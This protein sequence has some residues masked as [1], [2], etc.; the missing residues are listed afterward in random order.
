M[1]LIRPFEESDSPEM[2]EIEKLC[3]HGDEKYA[4]GVRKFDIISRYKMYDNWKV[5]VA[6]EDGRVV[7]WIGWTMKGETSSGTYTYLVE[8]MVHPEFR[9]K[10]IALELSKVVEERAREI[11]ANHIYCYIFEPNFASRSLFEMQGYTD[12]LD[13]K[14]CAKSVYKESKLSNKFQIERFAEEDL[15]EIIQLL[16]TYN[17]GYIHY[18]AFTPDSFLSHLNSIP[19]YGSDNYWVA[20]EGDR[21]AACAGLWDSSLIA[22]TCYTR[23]PFMWKLMG[24]ILRPLGKFMKVQKIPAEG[25][26]F[27]V[28]YITDYAFNSGASEAMQA[29]LDHLN[30]FL[31]EAGGECLAASLDENDPLFKV[32]GN[33]KPQIEVFKVY[34]K[35]LNGGL[36]GFSPFN[37]DIKDMVL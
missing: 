6:E 26:Y 36:P 15:P 22:E 16:N 14:T 13:A 1:V 28:H 27:K 33:L 32:I 25:E 4:M 7:G 18:A 8:V 19:G 3:P 29:L 37:V 11:G 31:L 10:G 30:N 12:V 20:R 35:S 2:L 5:I 17:T 23:M 21:I 9:R 34:A 24:S